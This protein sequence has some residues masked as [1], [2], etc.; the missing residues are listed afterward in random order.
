MKIT[1]PIIL[2][3]V[4]AA[5]AIWAITQNTTMQTPSES[6]PPETVSIDQA[7]ERI[8][9]DCYGSNQTKTCTFAGV[10]YRLDYV[11]NWDA[12]Q[13][14]RNQACEQGY[15]NDRLNILTDSKSWTLGTNHQAYLR[16]LHEA[17]QTTRTRFTIVP[18]SINR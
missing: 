9:A 10:E 5:I 13:K 18:Y 2:A 7:L 1:I 6:P 15:I 12:D 4:A 14:L 11:S 8:G 16:T 3:L 17:L